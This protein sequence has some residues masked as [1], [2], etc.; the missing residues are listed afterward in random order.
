MKASRFKIGILLLFIAVVPTQGF[1]IDKVY[2]GGILFENIT[3][4][5]ARTD[6]TPDGSTVGVSLDANYSKDCWEL[7]V[8]EYATESEDL[9]S[10]LDVTSGTELTVELFTYPVGDPQYSRGFYINGQDLMEFD[11]NPTFNKLKLKFK[12]TAPAQS[13]SHSGGWTASAGMNIYF[14]G[15]YQNPSEITYGP[16]V[17]MGNFLSDDADR[18]SHPSSAAFMGKVQNFNGINGQQGAFEYYLGSR[19]AMYKGYDLYNSEAYVDGTQPMS[20]FGWSVSTPSIPFSLGATEDFRLYAVYNANWS[21][22][23]IQVGQLPKRPEFTDIS[24]EPGGIQMYWDA[25][26]NKSYTLEYFPSLGG[27]TNVLATNLTG[28]GFLDSSTT[29]TSRFYRLLQE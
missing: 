28:L 23:D 18:G 19:H 15:T 22:R 25:D 20:D 24:V 13:A 14:R 10:G 17:I 26:T 8:Y 5:E 12:P 16:P 29:Q 27:P 4:S 11:Y 21:A 7:R 3:A 1:L 9:K 2:R 6:E